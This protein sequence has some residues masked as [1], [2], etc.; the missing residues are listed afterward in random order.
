[1][2]EDDARHLSFVFYIINEKIKLKCPEKNTNIVTVIVIITIF[3]IKARFPSGQRGRTVNPLVL[4]FAGSN[5][6]L[7]TIKVRE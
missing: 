5:P 6:A 1:M 7:A 3:E 2:L 4:A